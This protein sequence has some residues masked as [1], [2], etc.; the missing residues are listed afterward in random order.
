ML[1]SG[2]AQNACALV[3]GLFGSVASHLTLISQEMERGSCLVGGL[4]PKE[5]PC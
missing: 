5:I 1:A 3:L 4:G 2:A